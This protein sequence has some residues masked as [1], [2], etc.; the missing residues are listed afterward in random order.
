[1][2]SDKT[3]C[4][5]E[6]GGRCCKGSAIPLSADESTRLQVLAQSLHLSPPRIISTDSTPH[7]MQASPCTFLSKTNLCSIYADRPAHCRA[8]PG[9]Y[10]EWCALS[11]K[12]FG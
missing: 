7:L 5:R 6:C 1:V 11:W 10:L 2:K 12:R 9:D 4:A 3:I 8:F